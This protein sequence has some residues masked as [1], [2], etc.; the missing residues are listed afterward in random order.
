MNEG[1][2]EA[3]ALK[4]GSTTTTKASKYYRY[5]AYADPDVTVQLDF[6]FWLVRNSTRTVLI[7][8]GFD[9]ERASLRGYR[10]ETHPLELL[11]RRGV[12]ASQ[13]DHVVMSHMHFDHIGNLCLFP[14][15]TFS[16][17]RSEFD[18]WT[19]AFA[20]RDFLGHSGERE[21][22]KTVVELA[23]DG[24]VRLVD[25][26]AEL[27]PGISV[28]PVR[29]HTPGLL[30]TEV[31]T[32][33]GDLVFA[34]DAIH[35][36]EEMTL[37]RPYWVFHDLEGMYQGFQLLRDKQARPRTQIVAGHDPAVMA[38]FRTVDESCVDL[39]A[40]RSMEVALRSPS[41]S[42][43]PVKKPAQ[44]GEK[45]LRRDISYAVN[46]RCAAAVFHISTRGKARFMRISCAVPLRRDS[47]I[48]LP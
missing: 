45:P 46:L 1:L 3:Y 44:P 42:C 32:A 7:D 34:S 29:G 27:F 43:Q 28:T 24:R 40:A 5:E 41:T 10:Q 36:Y 18:F 22:T 31:A 26:T 13:V 23:K 12:D 38:M 15:A 37:D 47:G 9:A 35:F 8:C 14:N 21:E 30:I 16:V 20:D 4:Y 25:D 39:T 19:G 11:A 6:Y 48:F 2:Y 17:G 33:S